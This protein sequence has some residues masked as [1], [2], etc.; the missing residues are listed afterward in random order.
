MPD[1]A[2]TVIFTDSSLVA[3][4]T[5]VKSVHVTELRTAANAV[6]QLA[7]LAAPYI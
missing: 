5:V 4:T 1:L 3:G 7:G 6:R 2:T